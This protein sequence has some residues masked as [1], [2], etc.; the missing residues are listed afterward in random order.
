M[1]TKRELLLNT[2]SA[3]NRM[4]T[5]LFHLFLFSFLSSY[6]PLLLSCSASRLPGTTLSRAL[7]PRSCV[8]KK[9]KDCRGFLCHS[10]AT[11]P[12]TSLI[13]TKIQHRVN[14]WEFPFYLFFNFLI[15]LLASFSSVV[16]Q[17]EIS[18]IHRTLPVSFVYGWWYFFFWLLVPSWDCVCSCISSVTRSITSVTSVLRLVS[19]CPTN[20]L[21]LYS[22]SSS[23]SFSSSSSSFPFHMNSIDKFLSTIWFDTVAAPFLPFFIFK[24]RASFDFFSLH[25]ASNF[26]LLSVK[27]RLDGRSR[28]VTVSV[29]NDGTREP[30]ISHWKR[31]RPYELVASARLT[32]SLFLIFDSFH[33]DY[34]GRG[35]GGHDDWN[36]SND[37]GRSSWGGGG[38][39]GGAAYPPPS[40]YHRQQQHHGRGGYGYDQPN[41]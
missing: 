20:A 15:S 3:L 19:T 21:F 34:S 16:V 35:R 13:L 7:V 25:F 8:K 1:K 30:M 23:S 5:L 38:G 12:L 26:V 10:F 39:G 29:F 18:W 11:I 41:R 22:T 2:L 31:P 4:I 33:V 40:D 14:S 28:F 17:E 37:Q 9:R 24:T 27:S 6:G 32:N 36:R